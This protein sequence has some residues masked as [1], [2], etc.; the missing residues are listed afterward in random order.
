MWEWQLSDSEL[1][2]V[3]QQGAQMTLHLPAASARALG[4]PAGA[5]P[6]D[7]GYALGVAL[8]LTQARVQ[9]WDPH[10][11]GRIAQGTLS[12]D[13]QALAHLP[14]PGRGQGATQLVLRF[15][16]GAALQLLAQAWQCR[17]VAEPRFRE[18]YAC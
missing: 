16:N 14:L 13:G 5:P 6:S 3:Q 1:A 7:W 9:H 10:A 2:T 11:L 4:H 12:L 18:S 8:D 17:F 15:S